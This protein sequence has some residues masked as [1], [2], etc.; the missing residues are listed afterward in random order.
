MIPSGIKSEINL[1]KD[2]PKNIGINRLQLENFRNHSK[3]DIEVTSPIVALVGS[4]G[5]GKTSILEAISIFSAG[6]GMRNTSFQ[7]MIK[8]NCNNFFIKIEIYDEN[9][10]KSYISNIYDLSSNKRK[11]I[12]NDKEFNK[13]S[14]LRNSLVLLWISPAMERIFNNSPSYR[15]LFLDRIVLAFDQS[16]SER[17]NEFDKL[18]KE[19]TKILKEAINEH[20]WLDKVEDNLAKYSVAIAAARLDVISRVSHFFEK[21]VNCFPRGKIVF[22]NSVENLLE[23]KPAL[24]VETILKEKYFSDRKIDAIIGGSSSGSHRTDFFVINKSKDNLSAALCSSGEQKSLLLSI[25]LSSSR[26]I[27]KFLGKTPVLLLDEVYAHLDENRRISL[28]SEL[29][30]LNMQA[31]I[32]GTEKDQ[33]KNFNGN[34]CLYNLS[35]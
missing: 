34:Y 33:F 15:R 19:R 13:V 16:H 32:T 20:Y 22:K 21:P 3:I 10:L 28:T 8:I 25:I 6:K 7:D 26:A 2:F 23:E 27:Y 9:R 30:S 4:N 29:A 18:L 1:T 14:L 31:W 35:K 11:I 17:L 12:I 24:E 5:T